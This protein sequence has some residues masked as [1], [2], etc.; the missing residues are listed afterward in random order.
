MKEHTTVL[1]DEG[2]DALNVRPGFDY[3]DATVG[4]GGHTN[5]LLRRLDASNAYLGLDA[6]PTAIA[7]LQQSGLPATRACITLSVGNFRSLSSH[8]AEVRLGN[9]GG[10]L[11][12]LGWRMEQFSEGGKG[13]SFAKNEPLYMTYGNPDEYAFT[14]MDVI[15]DWSQEAIADVI[16]AYGEER[17]ARK[18][19][20][21][22][23]AAREKTQI[24]STGQLVDI[25]E[26]TLR[27]RGRSRIHP[28]TKTF[29][30][31]RIVVNDELSVVE[32]LIDEAYSVVAPTGRIAIITFHSLEDRIV[33][34]RFRALAESG[35]AVLTKKPITPTETEVQNNPRARSAK[36][37]IFEKYEP[38]TVTQQNRSKE[39]SLD[40]YP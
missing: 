9:V 14:A 26:M 8:V 31:L 29:Q 12:D 28:A 3:I 32:E 15:N 18:L 34:H 6:D 11:A 24:L 39:T 17:A 33:K 36:L 30:A 20:K 38:A 19:A 5:A 22:I 2:I 16:Y 10:V 7:S 1:L 21:A 35:G 27:P 4:A 37:R 13:F 25:I 40:I 23:V